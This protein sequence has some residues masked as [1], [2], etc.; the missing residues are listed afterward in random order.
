MR[1]VR[2]FLKVLKQGSKIAS[3]FRLE[4]LLGADFGASS[5]LA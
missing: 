4:A 2:I 5:Q 3:C 1:N